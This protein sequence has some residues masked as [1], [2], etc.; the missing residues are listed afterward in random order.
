M[1]HDGVK[2]AATGVVGGAV[3][4]G[5]YAIIGGIGVAVGGTAVGI[6][7]GPFI[8]IGSG[9]GLVGYGVYWL[10]KQIG[11]SGKK[12]GGDKQLPQS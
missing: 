2:A 9:L 12:K 10:G 11:V 3:G 5:T 8:A 7:L 4:A 6:T 1:V